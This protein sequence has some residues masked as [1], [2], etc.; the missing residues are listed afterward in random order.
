MA[1]ITPTQIQAHYF[2]QSRNRVQKQQPQEQ[3]SQKQQPQKQQP[4]EQQSQQQPKTRPYFG[5]YSHEWRETMQA[6][7]DDML[8]LFLILC[9]FTDSL[10]LT[11]TGVARLLAETGWGKP[12][13]DR[14]LAALMTA[15]FVRY[16]RFN[17]RDTLTKRQLANVY[18]VNPAVVL[19]RPQLMAEALAISPRPFG[20]GMEKQESRLA[21]D[22]QEENKGGLEQDGQEENK[23]GFETSTQSDSETNIYNQRSTPTIQKPTVVDIT[24]HPTNQEASKNPFKQK[25]SEN[26]GPSTISTPTSETP[27]QKTP[28]AAVQDD[29]PARETPERKTPDA[30]TQGDSPTSEALPTHHGG[31]A[32]A[33]TRDSSSK[34]P[35]RKIPDAPTQ[36]DS[37]TSEARPTHHARS[38]AARAASLAA[39][40]PEDFDPQLPLADPIQEAFVHELQATSNNLLSIANARAYITAYGVE[41][42]RF[43]INAVISDKTVKNVVGVMDWRLQNGFTAPKPTPAAE[44]DGRRYITGRYAEY[45]KY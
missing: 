39:R 33:P 20:T 27:E 25:I 23:G 22:G 40:L 36:S 6:M 4:Q 44:T 31:S 19:M 14:T 10:L 32:A 24:N 29:S 15:G 12:R 45:I 7:D 5:L 17:E 8:R 37:T 18:Q 16:I 38:A 28:D 3:Q 26:P 41:N 13:L 11:D 43:V 35:E 34:V 2:T 1:K 42:V 30:P 21:E 9:T